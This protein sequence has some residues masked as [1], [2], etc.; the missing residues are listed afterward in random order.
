[1]DS[2]DGAP[3]F[4]DSGLPIGELTAPKTGPDLWRTTHSFLKARSRIK[5]VPIA[6]QYRSRRLGFLWAH[7]ASFLYV[8]PSRLNIQGIVATVQPH[9]S[10]LLYVGQRLV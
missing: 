5:P 1:M 4:V 9:F 7:G 2:A 3:D 6:A 8:S 10:R